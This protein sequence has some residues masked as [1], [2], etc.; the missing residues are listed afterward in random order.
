MMIIYI[1]ILCGVFFFFFS[2][3]K[4]RSTN[5]SKILMNL[6]IALAVTNIIFILGQQEYTFESHVG[7]KVGTFE[8]KLESYT[9]LFVFSL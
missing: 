8:I 2:N 1:Y 6:C 3:R 5:P 4:L 9:G 7:C